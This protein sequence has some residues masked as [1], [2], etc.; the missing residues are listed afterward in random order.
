MSAFFS[1]KAKG[2][3]SFKKKKEADILPTDIST[4]GKRRRKITV[5]QKTFLDERGVPINISRPGTL[6]LK[7]VKSKK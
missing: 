1:T 5:A 6:R 4:V 2:L 3:G 7:S